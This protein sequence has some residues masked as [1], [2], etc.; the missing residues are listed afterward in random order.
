MNILC[1]DGRILWNPGAVLLNSLQ[2]NVKVI[3]PTSF[4]AWELRSGFVKNAH[5]SFV[6]SVFLLNLHGYMI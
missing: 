5:S 2:P 4:L 6:K 1:I 3:I